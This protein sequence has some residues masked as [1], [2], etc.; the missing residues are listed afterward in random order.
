MLTNF[1][2]LI[3]IAALLIFTLIRTWKKAVNEYNDNIDSWYEIMV[4]RIKH[5]TL[6]KTGMKIPNYE[7][8]VIIR[9]NSTK[10]VICKSILNQNDYTNLENRFDLTKMEFVN[11]VL[12]YTIYAHI[13]CNKLFANTVTDYINNNI[14]NNNKT[15]LLD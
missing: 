4:Y 10:E 6:T 15:L 5:H 3:V 2:G 7:Y 14:N 1:L 9:N 12:Y 13:I 11:N 8:E